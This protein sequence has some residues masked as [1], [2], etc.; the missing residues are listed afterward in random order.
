MIGNKQ[1]M[2]GFKK[3]LYNKGIDFVNGSYSCSVCQI[4][5]QKGDINSHLQ[6]KRHTKLAKSLKRK[7]KLVA[8]NEI[9]SRELIKIKEWKDGRKRW[10]CL[11]C[12][13]VIKFKCISK[14]HL[15]GRIHKATYERY[16]K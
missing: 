7:K 3:T 9:S 15:K 1:S 11:L 10:M 8:K 6:G 16:S 13:V 2:E 4:G 5:L 12:D 14:Y